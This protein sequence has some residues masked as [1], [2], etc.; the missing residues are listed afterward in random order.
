MNPLFLTLFLVFRLSSEL[1]MAFAWFDSDTDHVKVF[2]HR[3]NKSQTTFYLKTDE[4]K[5]AEFDYKFIFSSP[6]KKVTQSFHLV[7]KSQEKKKVDSYYV[8]VNPATGEEFY[9]VDEAFCDADASDE[10]SF[11]KEITFWV[12]AL[13]KGRVQV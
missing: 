1:C 6:N 12:K 4:K 11:F 10:S 13:G 7:N 8:S 2:F 9:V 3:K 5:A